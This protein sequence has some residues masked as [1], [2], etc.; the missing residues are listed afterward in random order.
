MFLTIEEV[1]KHLNIDSQFT[2]DDAYLESLVTVSEAIVEKH[3][4]MKLDVL[5]SKSGGTL[6]K[7]LLQAMLLQIGTLYENRESVAYAASNEVPN[8]YSYILS[9]YKNYSQNFN[10]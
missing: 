3:I 4:D 2:E 10:S 9:L 6:P 8:T 1:K 5:A 7:P